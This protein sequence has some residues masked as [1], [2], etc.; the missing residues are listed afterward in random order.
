MLRRWAQRDARKPAVI[1]HH[2]DGGRRK[3]TYAELNGRVNRFANALQVRGISRGD[4]VGVLHHNAIDHLIAYYAALKLGAIFTTM[5][6]SLRAGELALQIAGC[7]PSVLVVGPTV[8]EPVKLFLTQI[9]STPILISTGQADSQ[10]PFLSMTELMDNASEAEPVAFIEEDDPAMILYTSGSAATPKGVMLSHRNFLIATTPSWT[11]ERYI[12]ASDVFLLV[13]PLYTTAG[14]GTVTNL[15]NIGATAVLIDSATPERV[16]RVI[17][18][19]RVTNMS[20]TPTFYLQLVRSSRFGSADLSPLVQC[21]SYG[22]PIATPVVDAFSRRNPRILWAS[23]WGQTE[24]S[25]LGS[26][27][28]YRSLE[29]VPNAD[30]RWIGRPVPHLEVRVVDDEGNEAIE[31]ELL[32]RSP[33]M[34]IGYHNDDELT[35]A[36]T[37]NGW[38]HTGDIVRIDEGSNMFFVDRKVGVIKTGGM[39]V[40]SLEVE[41]VLMTHPAVADAAVIG[42]PDPYWSE[43]V[44]AFIVAKDATEVDIDDVIAFCG[45]WLTKYKL[46]KRIEI[47]A[48]LPRDGQGKILKRE[49]QRRHLA[50]TDHPEYDPS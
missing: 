10:G 33:A 15:L 11:I 19:E 22:G 21:H 42:T 29:D 3:V 48:T 14:L 44:A 12:E 13:A 43:V 16:L 34:M 38:L 6:P 9:E 36:V 27:G 4:V 40:S 41:T 32:C 8:G 28:F 47:V 20:Q 25:Q 30:P 1:E 24:L 45:K 39:N 35:A 17:G 49:L 46:P 7:K 18:I 50:Q 5:N 23:Y 26:I 37:A 2:G 31:G